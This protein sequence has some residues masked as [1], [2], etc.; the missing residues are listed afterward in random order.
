M[1]LTLNDTTFGE[2]RI[3]LSKGMVEIKQGQTTPVALHPDLLHKFLILLN[4]VRAQYA[5]KVS[6]EDLKAT[7]TFEGHKGATRIVQPVWDGG[8]LLEVEFYPKEFEITI[9]GKEEKISVGFSAAASITEVIQ[10]YLKEE[11]FSAI[12]D[13]TVVYKEEEA[14]RTQSIPFLM[15]FRATE[16]GDKH[17][18]LVY[19]NDEAHAVQRVNE[20]AQKMYKERYMPMEL[21][22]FLGNGRGVMNLTI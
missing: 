17:L 3:T 5:G 7:T 16:H 18:V 11:G 21:T 8:R 10:D 20:E 15:Q 22:D 19:A 1:T 4:N 14:V 12:Y 6:P 2:I 9:R 13:K